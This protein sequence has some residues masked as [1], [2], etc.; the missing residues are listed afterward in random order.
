MMQIFSSCN[1]SS[2]LSHNSKLGKDQCREEQLQERILQEL[3]AYQ[4]EDWMEL[5]P[6][7]QEMELETIR[8]LNNNNKISFRI[9]S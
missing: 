7:I 4:Q 5:D 3:L 1:S 8:Q 9:E 6:K 2:N